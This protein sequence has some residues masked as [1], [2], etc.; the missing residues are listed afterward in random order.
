MKKKYFILC[1]LIY[2]NSFSQNKE[3]NGTIFKN[4]PYVETVR[5]L[6]NTYSTNN[7]E[8]IKKEYQRISE[9]NL[10]F[11]DALNNMDLKNPQR[12]K[13]NLDKEM[14]NMSNIFN[15]HQIINIRELGYPVHLDY[16]EADD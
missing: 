11:R 7:I 16:K 4:G 5:S 6:M 2:V 9:D 12:K 8:K 14:D 10:F 1:F 13:M 15:T 3:S